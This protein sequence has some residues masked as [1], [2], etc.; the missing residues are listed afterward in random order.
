MQWIPFNTALKRSLVLI[1]HMYGF[2]AQKLC[3][4][5]KPNKVLLL[6]IMATKTKITLEMRDIYAISPSQN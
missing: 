4:Y 3:D 5:S 1:F 6:M 2:C